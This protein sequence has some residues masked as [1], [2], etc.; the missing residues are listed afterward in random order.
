MRTAS[1]GLAL[2]DF[3]PNI[4]Y[5]VA[6]LRIARMMSVAGA[7]GVALMMTVGAGLVFLA[8]ILKAASKLRDAMAERPVSESGFLY[9]QMFPS[10]AIGFLAT[11][12]SLI[13]FAGQGGAGRPAAAWAP[14]PAYI[15]HGALILLL[16]G[17]LSWA[18]AANRPGAS[19]RPA[20]RKL[21][22]MAMAAMIVLQFGGL[23]ILA[24]FA[25]GAGATPAG[26]F[27]NLSIASMLA[28]AALASPS[29]R[30]RFPDPIAMNWVDQG[31]NCLG[32]AFYAA[33][34]FL[35]L[36]P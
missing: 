1:R 28:M 11:T 8:G 16:L 20:Y 25:F 30:G 4:L 24:S 6:S 34:A 3:V 17:I 5:L 18:A 33:A 15:L 21:A 32:Q 19:S 23:A 14:G 7:G 22:R 27:V 35:I 12:S 36:L 10:M 13:A 31:V 26:V 2:V 9:D 29:M